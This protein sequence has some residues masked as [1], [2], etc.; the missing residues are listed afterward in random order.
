MPLPRLAE[1]LAALSLAGDLGEGHPLEHT[2][3]STYLACRIATRL[4]SDDVVRRDVLYT[5]LLQLVG[6]LANAHELT[7]RLVTDDIAFNKAVSH[8]HAD[9]DTRE[10]LSVVLA[11]VGAGRTIPGRVAAVARTLASP[12]LPSELA[13]QFCE[14]A[15]LVGRR[16]GLGHGVAEALRAIQE[17]WDG[18]G[19][20]AGLRGAHIPL[21]AR[22][23]RLAADVDVLRSTDGAEAATKAVT[24][25]RGRSLD[26]NV[27]DAY[28]QVARDG[29][30]E[31]L[32]A[33]TLWTD[34]LGCEPREPLVLRGDA[35][36]DV[37]SAFA[38]A[39]DLKSPNFVGHSRR[40]ATFSEGAARALHLSEN[41][42]VTIRRA[43]LLHDIGRASVPNTILDKP[44]PLTPGEHERVRL[45]AY[46]TARILSASP[47]LAELA[48]L[49]AAHHE[50]LDG[51][52]YPRG[53][54]ASELPMGARIIAV[55]DVCASLLEPRAYRPALPPETVARTLADNV[56]DG[57]LD[58]EVVS[59]VLLIA[60][61]ARTPR[62][63]ASSGLTEREIEVLRLVAEG[64]SNKE[65]ARRLVISENTARH[66]L[67]S[68]YAKLEVRS[69]AG[70]V[71]RGLER[72]LL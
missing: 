11:H 5:G 56:R 17:R 30:L 51:S 24:L 3:R 49:A 15:A 43:A 22:I 12:G 70:A 64:H 23:V 71:M 13:V 58:G 63:R 57:K 46:Y 60:F 42:C 52:G 72:G 37:A 25:R 20:P 61:G 36:D 65:L 68:V 67:E 27:A 48:P 18:G 38:D 44:T 40:V 9:Q 41:E 66:H 55:A 6:C 69:R 39:T 29:A 7:R 10:E 19:R 47:T 26:P 62:P 50:R 28:L 33:A 2:L 16:A 21:P 31:Q 8:A 1:V 45:H 34:V 32:D 4:G 14:V 59:A 35:L 54:R 53:S